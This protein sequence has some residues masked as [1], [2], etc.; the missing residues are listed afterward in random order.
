MWPYYNKPSRWTL[1]PNFM[2][3]ERAMLNMGICE[4]TVTHDTTE[5]GIGLSV[6]SHLDLKRIF[7]YIN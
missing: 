1:L 5:Y 6:S 4:S 2:H 3:D 7:Q